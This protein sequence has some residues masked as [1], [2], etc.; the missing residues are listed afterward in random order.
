MTRKDFELI[1]GAV[2]NAGSQFRRSQRTVADVTESLADALA[3]TNPNFDRDRF[4]AACAGETPPRKR[5][6]AGNALQLA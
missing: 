6:A 1:A 4:L 2:A 5:R 3:T